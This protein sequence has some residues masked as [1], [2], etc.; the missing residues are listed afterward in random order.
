MY[1]IGVVIDSLLSDGPVTYYG[2]PSRLRPLPQGVTVGTRSSNNRTSNTPH[3]SPPDPLRDKL[4]VV[5]PVSA[6]C[7]YFIK[8]VDRLSSLTCHKYNVLILI[9]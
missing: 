2:I 3:H 7:S 5:S 9:V 6:H 1:H 4:G 8:R